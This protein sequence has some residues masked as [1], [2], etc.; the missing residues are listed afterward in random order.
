MSSER[1]ARMRG[2]HGEKEPNMHLRSVAI[3]AAFLLLAACAQ[4]PNPSAA[5][6]AAGAGAASTGPRPGSEQD[7]AANT[8]D[9]VFFGF[10][11]SEL[12]PEARRT[13]QLWSAFLK[14]YPN[15]AVTIEGHC[16]E[17]GTREYNLALGA[18][19]A[20]MTKNFLIALGIDAKRVATVSYGKERP[21][22]LGSSEAAWSQNRRA[23]MVVN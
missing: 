18:R 9:R 1:A 5:T 6:A 21:A 22:I 15:A 7:L 10:D 2:G 14:R 20:A 13:I 17:R 8:G 12:T 4:A 11:K 23:V 16:D 3:V 19:R